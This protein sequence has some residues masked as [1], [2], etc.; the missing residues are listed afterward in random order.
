M[1]DT[2]EARFISEH[3]AQRYLPH[4]LH[5]IAKVFKSILRREIALGLC[6]ISLRQPHRFSSLYR[7]VAGLL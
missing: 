7:A 4:F 2:A 6:T 3:D 5:G 1:I